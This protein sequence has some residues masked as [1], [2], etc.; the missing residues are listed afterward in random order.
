MYKLWVIRV[1]KCTLHISE[2][3]GKWWITIN[4]KSTKKTQLIMENHVFVYEKSVNV[5][6]FD[7]KE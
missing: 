7:S 6:L 3:N 1:N 2:I 4:E 5:Y